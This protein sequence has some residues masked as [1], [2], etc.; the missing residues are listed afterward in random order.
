MENYTPKIHEKG[1]Y[2]EMLIEAERCKCCDKIMISKLEDNSIFPHYIKI[3]QKA[4]MEAAS[5]VYS[6][7]I[8]VDD[9]RICVECEQADKATILCALCK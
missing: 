7:N 1:R 8:L 5:L 2:V 4:Q 3:N 6:S 9:R